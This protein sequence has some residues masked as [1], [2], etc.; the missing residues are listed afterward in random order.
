MNNYSKNKNFT[1]YI[2]TLLGLYIASQIL[3]PLSSNIIISNIINIILV[4]SYIAYKIVQRNSYFK[5]NSFL[6]TY[7][8]FLIFS[9]SSL[10]WT[11][12]FF[13]TLDSTKTIFILTITIY[14][15]YNICKE[16]EN[17]TNFILYGLIFSAFVNY[18]IALGLY[19]YVTEFTNPIR[20]V[21]TL[22]RSTNL[23]ITMIM[24]LFASLYLLQ[25]HSNSKL[26]QI[27]LFTSVIM[28]LYT[29]MLTVAKKGI[30]ISLLLVVGYILI[31]SKSIKKMVKMTFFIV[32]TLVIISS[33]YSTEF[34]LAIENI[35]DRFSD[36]NLAIDSTNQ[37]SSTGERLYFINRG[38]EIISNNPFL[39][40]GLDTFRFQN[41]FNTY[42]HNNYIEIGSNLGLIGFIIYYSIYVIL[43]INIRF[44]KNNIEKYLIFLLLIGFLL[45]DFALISY[46]YK[47]MIFILL[48]ISIKEDHGYSYEKS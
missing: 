24:S 16:F 25:K 33:F 45:M 5:I 39:G 1:L 11:I 3:F 31:N 10:L 19:E 7:T 17:A 4:I 2:N 35:L 42:S 15:I 34:L 28:S 6:I 9:F 18:L 22:A 26:I 40:T 46:N 29:V 21:G 32:T 13:T 23:A 8:L 14:I 20:L 30:I 43:I 36:F 47:L 41:H 12:D 37:H 27:I 48:F 38:L 44:I